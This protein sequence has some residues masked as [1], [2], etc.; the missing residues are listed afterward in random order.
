VNNAAYTE[1]DRSRAGMW[2][3]AH[4]PENFRL[5]V[6]FGAPSFYSNRF[7]YDYSGLNMTGNTDYYHLVE[8]VKPELVILCPFNS[9]APPTAFRPPAGY[10]IAKYFDSAQRSGWNDFYAVVLV[11]SDVT[12]QVSM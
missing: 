1:A 3:A 2:V 7:V 6:G 8:T 10:V 5:A 11:R 4:T 12:G 9:H